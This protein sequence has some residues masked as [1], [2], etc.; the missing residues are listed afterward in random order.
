MALVVAVGGAI[1][2]GDVSPLDIENRIVSSVDARVG[3]RALW[4]DVFVWVLP[5]VSVAALLALVLWVLAHRWW[6]GVA[7]CAG[8]PL[9]VVVTTY[10]VKPLVDR[11]VGGTSVLMYPSGHVS[12]LGATV[13]VL[14][15]VL[16]PWVTRPALRAALALGLLA[17]CCIGAFAAI[18]SHQHGPA[19][20]VAGL[21]AGAAVALFWIMVVDRFA[22]RRPASTSS[23][24][25]GED[26]PP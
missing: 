26:V 17:I 1:V 25:P 15:V 4:D 18:A 12:G 19:D 9:A 21:P 6:R 11:R 2:H 24:A 13:V 7:A 23:L 5:R 8:V 20:A 3:D 16:A 22:E 10:A 14:A